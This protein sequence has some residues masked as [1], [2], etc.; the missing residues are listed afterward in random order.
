MIPDSIVLH[1]S[2]TTDGST[3][4]WPAIRKYHTSH[5][6]GGQ[7]VS[8]DQVPWLVQSGRYVERPWRD[9]GYHFGIELVNEHFE[10][11]IGRVMTETGAHCSSGGMNKRSLGV[12]FVGNF[13]DSLPPVMQWKIGLRLVKSLMVVFDISLG[14][15]Y[16]HRE[17]A[18][19]KSCPGRRFDLKRFREELMTV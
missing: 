19:Y 4:S 18:R 15:V 1:H 13:D 7:I 17:I 5:R 2:A 12:C 9:I 8:A 6:C 3:F 11:M 10:A 16:G 14:R